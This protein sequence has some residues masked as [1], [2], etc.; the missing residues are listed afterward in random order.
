MECYLPGLT[1]CV[2]SFLLQPLIVVSIGRLTASY[3]VLVPLE[4]IP[5][6]PPLYAC[7]IVLFCTLQKGSTF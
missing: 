5:S 1:G 3:A 4:F 2:A 6:E 7:V